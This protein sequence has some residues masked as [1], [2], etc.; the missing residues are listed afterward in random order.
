[1]NFSYD[2]SFR[3]SEFNFY[4]EQ[5]LTKFYLLHQQTLNYYHVSIVT[6]LLD[7][8]NKRLFFIHNNQRSNF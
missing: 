4:C 5:F 6:S 8:Q 1:M 3:E 7:I 2:E